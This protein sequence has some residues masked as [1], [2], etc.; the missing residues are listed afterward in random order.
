MQLFDILK[1]GKRPLRRAFIHYGRKTSFLI[2]P[3]QGAAGLGEDGADFGGIRIAGRNA[4]GIRA[5]TGRISTI[6]TNIF[7]QK[8]RQMCSGIPGIRF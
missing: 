4:P 5:T 1:S 7:H 3:G 8:E 2:N 6:Q